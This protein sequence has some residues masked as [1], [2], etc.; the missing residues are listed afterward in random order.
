MKAI[1]TED[2][3][4]FSPTRHPHLPRPAPFKSITPLQ[5]VTI[6]D[7]WDLIHFGSEAAH[8][9]TDDDHDL[10]VKHR[11][12]FRS[13]DVLLQIMIEGYIRSIIAGNVDQIHP[14]VEFHL[15]SDDINPP[16]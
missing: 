11:L 8:R 6:M 7:Y 16:L 10:M 3:L 9:R 5:L 1:L 14:Y 2:C 13:R 4:R 12:K 15:G